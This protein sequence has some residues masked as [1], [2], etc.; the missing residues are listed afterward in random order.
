M[1]TRLIGAL[2]LSGLFQTLCMPT[3]LANSN[4]LVGK[5][6]ETDAAGRFFAGPGVCTF[7]TGPRADLEA[8]HFLLTVG[9]RQPRDLL[10]TDAAEAG[11]L[12]VTGT[13]TVG[14]GGRVFNL[15]PD[16]AAAEQYIQADQRA[17]LADKYAVFTLQGLNVAVKRT[18]PGQVNCNVSMSGQVKATAAPPRSISLSFKG[19]GTYF[20]GGAS[21]PAAQSGGK[22]VLAAASCPTSDLAPLGLAPVP[23]Q[24][25]T[26][27]CLVNFKGYQWWTSFQYYGDGSYFPGGGYF[28][29]GGLQTIFAPKNVFV[30]GEGLHLTMAVRDLGGGP[31]PAGSEAVLMFDAGGSQANL[32]YG[33]Y[34]VTARVKT[35]TSWATLD[36]NAAFGA[37]TFE[38]IG[39]GSGG[40]SINP[41]REIDLAEISR[42]GW[43][44]TGNCP[45][46]GN[47][48][49]LCNGNAQFTLQ[50]WNSESANL[51]RYTIQDGIDTITLVMQWH[52]ANQP[53]TFSQYDGAFTFATLPAT[54]DNTWTTSSDQNQYVPATNCER[55]HLNFWMGNYGA[56]VNGVNPPP[57]I[58]PQE[59]VV[60]NF[61]F[62]VPQ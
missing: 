56:A 44:H 20:P 31:V 19:A 33:D 27:Q 55:F 40:P 41:H 49:P 62:R 2:F 9:D 5:F 61:E 50:P 25:D 42:W 13:F 30:D 37:F 16:T 54:P 21:Q 38:R 7:I 4:M 24:C 34:L 10:A 29:N 57:S 6:R 43:D 36:P 14:T 45:F 32:G 39:T 28:Y 58:L 59:V 1:K 8:G 17:H 46:S 15:I 52:G 11:E 51:H 53:V 23:A 18:R 3:V 35:A 48:A 60:T 22:S 47:S 26:A 12:Q